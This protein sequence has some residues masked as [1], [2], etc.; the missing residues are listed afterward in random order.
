MKILKK[1]TFDLVSGSAIMNG[2]FISCI[3]VSFNTLYTGKLYQC[4]MLDESI[5]HFRDI[6]FVCRF[7]SIFKENPV[8]KQCRP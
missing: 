3:H 1:K 8:S 4:Y 6:W 5:C 2:S 7:S